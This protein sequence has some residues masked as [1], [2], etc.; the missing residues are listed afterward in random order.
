MAEHAIYLPVCPSSQPNLLILLHTLFRFM[1]IFLDR[2]ESIRFRKL[3]PI[4]R[5]SSEEAN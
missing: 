3:A 5:F 2:I 1:H 4:K